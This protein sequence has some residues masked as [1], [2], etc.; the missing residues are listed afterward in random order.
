MVWVVASTFVLHE[1][2]PLAAAIDLSAG[3]AVLQT[4][5]EVRDAAQRALAEGAT[6]YTDRPGIAPLRRLVAERIEAERGIVADPAAGVLITCGDQEALFAALQVHAG[7]GD[8]V[9]IPGPAPASDLE[10]VRMVGAAARVADPGDGLALDAD[11]VAALAGPRTRVLL[12]RAPSVIGVTVP[13]PALERL[14]ALA[15]EHDL[16][17][18]AVESGAALLAAGT[19]QDSLAALPGMAPRTITVGDFSAAGL[20]AWRVGWA[21]AQGELM[22]PMRRLKQELSICSPAVSQYAALAALQASEPDGAPA[23]SE[24][25]RRRVAVVEV[26]AAAEIAT[27]EASGPVVL[28]DPGPLTAAEALGEAAG[29]GVLLSDAAELGA[30]GWLA[31]TL[32]A[33]PEILAAAAGRLAGALGAGARLA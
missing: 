30:P 25:A 22:G 5:P 20:G 1:R 21:A 33:S 24:L 13:R 9:L 12:V 4:T 6:H 15:V 10:L 2:E 8:E 7:I 18:I 23:R 11:A 27:L 32:A 16:R 26:L 3:R 14:A 19:T 31:L 28:L 17:V 29:C